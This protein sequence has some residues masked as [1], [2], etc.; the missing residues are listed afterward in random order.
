VARPGGP[1]VWLSVC[2]HRLR[3]FA[4]PYLLIL[5]HHIVAGD[6]RIVAPVVPARGGRVTLLAP[7][8]TIGAADHRVMLLDMTSAPVAAI[9]AAVEAA[10]LADTAALTAGLDAI[11][12]GCPV[13]V[14]I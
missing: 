3:G 11:F 10:E 9:G 12:Q 1:L 7:R 13:G 8:V 4:A 14:P 2:R 5:Q 6:T